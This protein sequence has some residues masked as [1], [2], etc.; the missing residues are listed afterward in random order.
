ML[1][2]NCFG[3]KQG[4]IGGPGVSA[5]VRCNRFIAQAGVYA[6]VSSHGMAPRHPGHPVAHLVQLRLR[7]MPPCILSRC[8][9]V[10]SFHENVPSLVSCPWHFR[11]LLLVAYARHGLLPERPD[12]LL[13]TPH[14]QGSLG[15]PPP[16]AA[17]GGERKGAARPLLWL[18]M[19]AA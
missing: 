14:T 19:L 16:P 13:C 2:C 12:F 7:L 8:H 17:G 3:C 11:P 5:G 4:R 10:R 15:T 18:R 6:R 9:A 1:A